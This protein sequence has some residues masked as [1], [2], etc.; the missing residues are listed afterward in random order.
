MSLLRRHRLHWWLATWVMFLAPVAAS[1]ER[2]ALEQLNRLDQPAGEIS[3]LKPKIMMLFTPACR[4]CS[5][6]QALMARLQKYCPG[7][8]Q[9]LVGIQSAAPAL[10]QQ[11][12]AW[13]SPLPLYHADV[14]WLRQIGGVDATPTTLFVTADHQL[15]AKHRGLLSQ[16]QLLDAYQAI[17]ESSCVLP[18]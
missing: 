5:K 8:E 14:R 9:W 12:Q 16:Q 10:K 15:L 2:L 3:L 1:V 11:W 17:T 18:D 13:Q 6:Q 7:A 4:F